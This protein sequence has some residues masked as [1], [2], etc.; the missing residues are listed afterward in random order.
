MPKDSREYLANERTFL[1]WVRTGIAIMAFGF[2]VVKFSLFL[3]QLS[4]ITQQEMLIHKGYSSVIGAF[5]LIGGAAVIP[6]AYF[7]FKQVNKQL[8]EGSYDEKHFMPTLLTVL[9]SIVSAS[10][11]VY[12][13]ITSI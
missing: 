8:S 9:L 7:R 2:V 6:I 5:I 11:L 1:A 10:L 4:I 12:I 13:I 3:R